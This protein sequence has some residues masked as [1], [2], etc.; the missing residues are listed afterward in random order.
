MSFRQTPTT[1]ANIELCIQRAK[2]HQQ[3]RG[4][5]KK[6]TNGLD[7]LAPEN[8]HSFQL[9]IEPDAVNSLLRRFSRTHERTAFVATTRGHRVALLLSG[10]RATPSPTHPPPTTDNEQPKT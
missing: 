4:G 9:I 6:E 7:R 8:G 2:R 5:G 3:H 10:E 1:R